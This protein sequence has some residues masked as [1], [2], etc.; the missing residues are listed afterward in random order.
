KEALDTQLLHG[1][2]VRRAECGDGGEQAQRDFSL[3]EVHGQHRRLEFFQRWHMRQRWYTGIVEETLQEGFGV[4]GPV[5]DSI[6]LDPSEEMDGDIL[7]IDEQWTQPI[8]RQQP[9]RQ[10]DSARGSRIGSWSRQK[11]R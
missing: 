9:F 6:R 8:G 7:P 11:G 3:A 2:I 10:I 1:D 5:S 4:W